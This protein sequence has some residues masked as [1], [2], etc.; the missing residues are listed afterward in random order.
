MSRN[1]VEAVTHAGA[2]ERARGLTDH[3]WI[4]VEQLGPIKRF[5]L[6]LAPTV[7]LKPR[8]LGER[9]GLVSENG[10][11]TFVEG[12]PTRASTSRS[13]WATSGLSIRSTEPRS[14]SAGWT[15]EPGGAYVIDPA[16]TNLEAV[17]HN[18]P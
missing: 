14:Q 13:A 18:R 12:R 15:T 2:R 6:A 7:C 8:S 17:F 11:F 16:G 10:S 5:Y 1:S 4:R 3:L 9:F